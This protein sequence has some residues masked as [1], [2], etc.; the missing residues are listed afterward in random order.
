MISKKLIG[1]VYCVLQ[2]CYIHFKHNK[3]WVNQ[4]GYRI[5]S[6][7]EPN[8]MFFVCRYCHHCKIF[9]I[10]L[11]VTELTCNAI[12]HLAQKLPGHSYNCMGKL[13]SVTLPQ[14][15]PTLKVMAKSGIE[16]SQGIANKLRNF[17]V[18]RF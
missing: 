2:S 11:E 14:D 1:S 13:D 16:I 7:C 3:S 17:D 8:R 12:N 4:Y 15:Q 5:A 6:L 10:Y 18:Q 9:C